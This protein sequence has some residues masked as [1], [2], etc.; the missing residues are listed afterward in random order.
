MITQ[1]LYQNPLIK[2]NLK[3][4]VIYLIGYFLASHYRP[5]QN[6]NG[7]YDFGIADSGLSMGA[8]IFVY[9]VLTPPYKSISKAKTNAL[10]LLFI[11]LSQEIYCFFF[12]GFV[13]TFD[14][15]DIFFCLFGFGVIYWGDV[16]RR[17]AL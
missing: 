8:I 3:I 2:H 10:S 5:F 13:G 7:F 15:K 6:N 1:R 16:L 12:P 4:L 9:L 14:Y 11:Y 17:D